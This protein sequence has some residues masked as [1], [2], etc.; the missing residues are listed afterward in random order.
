[1]N[2]STIRSTASASSLTGGEFMFATGIECS[3]PTIIG[4]DGQRQRI[5]E[6]EKCFHYQRWREDL[7]L[8]RELGLRYLR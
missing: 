5:D 3:Y 1:M 6:L 8:V 4:R 7:Q 2:A